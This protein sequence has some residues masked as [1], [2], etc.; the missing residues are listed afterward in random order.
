METNLNL[1]NPLRLSMLLEQRGRKLERMQAHLQLRRS[2]EME[3]DLPLLLL[4]GG[5]AQLELS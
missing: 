2:W 3:P 5:Q 1:K 4:A